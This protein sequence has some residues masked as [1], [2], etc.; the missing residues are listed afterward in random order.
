MQSAVSS[1][2]TGRR[3][4]ASEFIDSLCA[5]PTHFYKHSIAS[6]IGE[7]TEMRIKVKVNVVN[8]Q[9]DYRLLLLRR[10]PWCEPT[11]PALPETNWGLVHT[12]TNTWHRSVA[13]G[14][15]VPSDDGCL[16][17]CRLR[18]GHVVGGAAVT[19]NCADKVVIIA[20]EVYALEY[21]N[22]NQSAD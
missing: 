13:R 2:Q 15:V 9:L 5:E 1:Y 11:T 10:P 4:G 21:T 16:S 17:P 3:K 12:H 14:E 6:E 19:W 8:Y 7:W 22:R 18:G 20:A